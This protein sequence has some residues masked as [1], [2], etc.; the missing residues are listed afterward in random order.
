MNNQ[1]NIDCYTLYDATVEMMALSQINIKKYVAPHL[2][3][4]KQSFRDI[5]WN[6]LY[7]TNNLWLTVQAGDPYPYV[8]LPRDAQRVLFAARVD[9]CG[10]IK[11]LFYNNVMN[12][13]P[14]PSQKKC[15][16]Q[17]C[18][19]G[20]LCEDLNST[21]FT[22]NVLFIINGVSYSEKIWIKYGKDGSVLEYKETPYKQYNDTVGDG[23]DFN[24][25][26]NNDY[27]MGGS[28]LANF[29]IAYRTSQRKLCALTTY[30][31]GCPMDIPENECLVRDNCACFM[32]YFG[33]RRREHCEHFLTDSNR[34]EYGEVKLSEC[35]TKLYFRPGRHHRH[36]NRIPDH[37][38]VGYQTNG[39]PK[40]L[41]EQIK[42]PEFAKVCVWAGIDYY[43]KL[44]NSKYSLV[45]RREA[46]YVF[47]D[48]QNDLI[49]FLNPLSFQDMSDVQ[50]APNRW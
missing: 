49:G 1:R 45:E 44:F 23:G 26:F 24:D 40:L 41:N 3:A 13:I 16:C 32:P 6:T 8:S 28:G 11:P 2:I 15:G 19:C 14:R 38:L 4:A 9:H 33:K 18:E 25:D 7:V 12:V 22:S 43:K 37:I 36:A 29:N 5:F 31:C 48:K 27:S 21:I 34:S 50:D 46:K 20:G 10:D 35:G 39:D 42:V 30:P 47:N 17:S